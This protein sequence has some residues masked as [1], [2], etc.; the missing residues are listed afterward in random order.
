MMLK[1]LY[2][3]GLDMRGKPGWPVEMYEERK[4]RWE[5]LLTQNGELRENGILC[6]DQRNDPVLVQAPDRPNNKVA[7]LIVDNPE[8]VLGMGTNGPKNHD[9]YMELLLKCAEETGD[10]GVTAVSE[11][12]RHHLDDLLFAMKAIGFE[13]SGQE[14]GQKAAEWINF[15]VGGSYPVDTPA[16]QAWWANY[17]RDEIDCSEICC[18]SGTRGKVTRKFPV[19][20]RLI[21]ADSKMYYCMLASVDS[22]ACKSYGYDKTDHAPISHDAALVA[23]LAL[24][25]LISDPES[26]RQFGGLNFAFW[27]RDRQIRSGLSALISTREEDAVRISQVKA[28][29]DSVFSGR[30]HYP[31]ADK[32]YMLAA[33]NTKTRAV[34]RASFEISLGDVVE[35]VRWW[36]DAVE[37]CGPG[38]EFVT[39]SRLHDAVKVTNRRQDQAAGLQ[40]VNRALF[41][42]QLSRPI[43]ASVFPRVISAIHAKDR[44]GN[45]KRPQWRCPTKEQVSIIKLYLSQRNPEVKELMALRE[46]FP[47]IAYHYG[48]LLAAYEAIQIDASPNVQSTVTERFISAMMINPKRTVAKL[49]VLARAHLRKAAREKGKGCEVNHSKRLQSINNRLSV[50]GVAEQGT[51][52]LEQR[53]L[54][55]LGYWHEKFKT[56]NPNK[57]ED[58]QDAAGSEDTTEGN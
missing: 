50:L 48:R 56:Y 3:I 14:K 20:V 33:T 1:E 26:S 54:F 28:L 51:L 47:D 55:V 5:V 53:G 57:K 12:L 45:K 38:P 16:V 40:F 49:D 34:V 35:H 21:G 13:D 43:Y 19:K 46:D 2:R 9:K 52:S 22:A 18:I 36:F 10:P 11:M 24:R 6:F 31:R 39:A 41:G 4:I 30:A 58:V 44:G 27:T 42:K 37:L 7:C 25:N 8:Y 32:F 15:R 29:F 17:A 23:G